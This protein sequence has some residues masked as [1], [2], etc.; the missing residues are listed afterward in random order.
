MSFLLEYFYSPTEWIRWQL[1]RHHDE[2]RDFDSPR[3]VDQT[4]ESFQLSPTFGQFV[5]YFRVKN[6]LLSYFSHALNSFT[7]HIVPLNELS[8][9]PNEISNFSL[10][11][12]VC[13]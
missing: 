3:P 12:V 13:S 1:E 10:T 7:F 2:G 5:A 8:L 9:G 4:F 6:D 11:L